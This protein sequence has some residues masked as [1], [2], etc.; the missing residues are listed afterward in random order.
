[1]VGHFPT[2]WIAIVKQAF[3]H[4][5]EP[6]LLTSQVIT[7]VSMSITR[8]ARYRSATLPS[9]WEKTEIIVKVTS[10]H[11]Y[12][13]TIKLMTLALGTCSVFVGPWVL[14][15]HAELKL[16]VHGVRATSNH[17]TQSL[18][19]KKQNQAKTK[20]RTKQNKSKYLIHVSLGTKFLKK[21]RAFFGVNRGQIQRFLKGS[22]NLIPWD[23]RYNFRKLNSVSQI[24]IYWRSFA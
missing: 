24:D 5:V 6:W 10:H 7:V 15:L 4:V 21:N 18:I 13:R 17:G 20:Q 8:S 2:A 14:L 11:P 19:K 16:H 23:I 12:I 9:L 3:W 1:M 22:L